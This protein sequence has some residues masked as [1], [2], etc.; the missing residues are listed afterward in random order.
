MFMKIINYEDRYFNQTAELLADFR[1]TLKA[2]KGMRDKPDI[3]AAK[4]ELNSFIKDNNY[5]IYLCVKDNTVLGYMILK[6]DGVIWVEQIFVKE[7]YRRKGVATL[8][9][10][11]AEEESKLI[12]EDTLYNYVHPNNDVMIFFLKSKGYDVL[13]LIEIRKPYD[14]EDNKEIIQIKNN[15]FRY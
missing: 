14:K 1:V 5:P 4:E 3:I 13:N 7:S 6:K 10:N 9:Y 8:L 11:K 12:G 15:K 2:F